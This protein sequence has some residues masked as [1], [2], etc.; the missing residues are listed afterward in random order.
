M[1]A[2]NASALA[3]ADVIAS[4]VTEAMKGASAKLT[5]RAKNGEQHDRPVTHHL[6][7]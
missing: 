6:E 1:P 3:P 7:P 2:L 4:V 5:V